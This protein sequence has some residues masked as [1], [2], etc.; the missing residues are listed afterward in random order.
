MAVD[1]D[2]RQFAGNDGYTDR[3]DIFY[4][5]DSSVPRCEDVR[6]SDIVALWDKHSLIGVS[7]VERIDPGEGPKTIYRCKECKKASIKRRKGKRPLFRCHNQNCKAEFDDPLT[8]TVRVDTYRSVHDAAW[9]P[10]SG[11][12]SG[13]QLRALCEKPGSQHAIRPLR[14][15]DFA[16]ALV[17]AGRSAD[18]DTVEQRSDRAG[19]GHKQVLTRVRVGQPAFRRQLLSQ[20]GEVCALT[21][22]CPRDVLE[23]GHL[24]SYA[25]LG[26]HHTHGG[27]L[28]RRD[29]HEL[30]DRGKLAIHPDL[31]TISVDDRLNGFAMYSELA[32]RS[33]QVAVTEKHRQWLREHWAQHRGVA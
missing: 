30:F 20:F 12:L 28:L 15:D 26:K 14:W 4:S 13:Q 31:L 27:V 19:N 9:R 2:D 6:A 21:G 11:V 32:G 29:I 25:K 24:Y 3:P 16:A 22:S 18:V 10:L 23:A 33:V 8:E 7:V 17:A 1:A 5:W